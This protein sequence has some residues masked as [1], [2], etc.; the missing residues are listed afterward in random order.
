MGRAQPTNNTLP[1]LQQFGPWVLG[2]MAAHQT[3]RLLPD[4]GLCGP[5]ELAGPILAWQRGGP[6]PITQAYRPDQ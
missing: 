2:W 4:C 6:Q 3:K 1:A 5:F